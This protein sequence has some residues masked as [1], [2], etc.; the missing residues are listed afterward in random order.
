[1]WFIS[2]NIERVPRKK[3]L[4]RAKTCQVKKSLDYIGPN[5]I[6]MSREAQ[7]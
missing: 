3:L 5:S 6:P 1:V 7:V 2:E 4:F